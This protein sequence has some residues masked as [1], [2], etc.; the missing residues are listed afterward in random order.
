VDAMTELN[1]T[2]G[3]LVN[4]AV[5]WQGDEKYFR[6]DCKC[7]GSRTVLARSFNNRSVTCCE[8][9]VAKGRWKSFYTP[10]RVKVP[11]GEGTVY[12]TMDDDV[13]ALLGFDVAQ[14][15]PTGKEVRSLLSEFALLVRDAGRSLHLTPDQWEALRT[16]AEKGLPAPDATPTVRVTLLWRSCLP[17]VLMPDLSAVESVAVLSALRWGIAHPEVERW[18]EPDVRT[19]DEG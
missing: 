10:E 4:K 7:G 5:V 17:T 15:K 6:C 18:W 11:I 9:C 8:G 12:T 14:E 2:V 13:M 1:R 3:R 19:G 16:A